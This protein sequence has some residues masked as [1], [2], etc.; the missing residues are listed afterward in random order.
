[1]NTTHVYLD[2]EIRRTIE[3]LDKEGKLLNITMEELEKK[4]VNLQNKFT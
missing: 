3:Q 4:I 2:V 1:M